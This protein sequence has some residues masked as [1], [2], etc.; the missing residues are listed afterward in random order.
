MQLRLYHVF[1]IVGLLLAIG[2]VYLIIKG[3]RDPGAILYKQ[4]CESCHMDDGTGLEELIPP[5]AGSD[6]LVNNQEKLACLIR[7]GMKGP[8]VVNGVKYDNT[9]DPNEKLNDGQ[10]YNIITYI[11]TAWGNDLPRPNLRE[12]K[13]QLKRCGE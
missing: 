13:E 12:V 7:E 10:I 11:N 3:D 2:V 8:L 5:L 6:W 4:E 9:M 1:A